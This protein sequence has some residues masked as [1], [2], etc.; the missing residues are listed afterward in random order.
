ME[1]T[2]KNKLA[3]LN[4][5]ES[6]NKICATVEFR[7]LEIIE[8]QNR[9][10]KSTYAKWRHTSNYLLENLYRNSSFELQL[11]FAKCH[12]SA[13]V[14]NEFLYKLRVIKRKLIYFFVHPVNQAILI[15]SFCSQSLFSKWNLQVTRKL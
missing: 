11:D 8:L 12:I 5:M 10:I 4:H 3:R 13:G 15:W 7:R 2:N 14:V 1:C 9:T 6:W